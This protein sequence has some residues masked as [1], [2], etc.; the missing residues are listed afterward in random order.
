[1]LL[2][3]REFLSLSCL[4]IAFVGIFISAQ[5][6]IRRQHYAQLHN[7]AELL[8]AEK[9]RLNYELAFARRHLKQATG[10]IPPASDDDRSSTCSSMTIKSPLAL[11]VR[12]SRALSSST[13]GP[14]S[15]GKS[16]FMSELGSAMALLHDHNSVS[17]ISRN[18]DA[19]DLDHSMLRVATP[20]PSA[21][22]LAREQ[23]L[24]DTLK[25]S[26]IIPTET[27]I[28]S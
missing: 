21:M 17:P 18:V 7:M 12:Q 11:W 10:G 24:W 4:I 13:R 28:A 23:V 22:Q 14:G 26:G 9:E 27:D 6:Y 3:H 8:R 2:S 19:L 5:L 1:M 25:R 16:S 20:P 15:S